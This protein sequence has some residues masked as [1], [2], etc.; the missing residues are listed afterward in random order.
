MRRGKQRKQKRRGESKGRG[1]TVITI[2]CSFK[3][4][5]AGFTFLNGACQID[6]AQSLPRKPLH[7]QKAG[8]KTSDGL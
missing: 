8:E 4:K 7:E 2:T 1:D 3:H 5:M 6:K